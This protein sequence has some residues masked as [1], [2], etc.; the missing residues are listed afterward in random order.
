MGDDE[1]TTW[2]LF[3]SSRD[4]KIPSFRIADA[5]TGDGLP[6]R[7]SW[8]NMESGQVPSIGPVYSIPKS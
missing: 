6:Q 3:Q 7:R 2:L 5:E 1:Q 4:H 8:H